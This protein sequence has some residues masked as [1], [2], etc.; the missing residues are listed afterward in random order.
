MKLTGL[1]NTQIQIQKWSIGFREKKEIMASSTLCD[2]SED[3]LI[4]EFPAVLVVSLGQLL[5]VF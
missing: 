4:F 1:R 3:D 2:F 5:H